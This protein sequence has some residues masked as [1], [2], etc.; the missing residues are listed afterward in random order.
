M[1]ESRED[2]DAISAPLPIM[3]R[4]MVS[5]S[6]TGGSVFRQYRN[7]GRDTPTDASR[8]RRRLENDE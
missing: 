6:Y 5:F 4:G 8:D 1:R 2:I 3:R 7:L